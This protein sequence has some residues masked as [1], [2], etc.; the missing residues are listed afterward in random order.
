MAVDNIRSLDAAYSGKT[1]LLL[2]QLPLLPSRP[3]SKGSTVP[4]NLLFTHQCS[5]TAKSIAGT[6]SLMRSYSKDFLLKRK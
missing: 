4:T 5:N 6:C 3:L 1:L 2:V